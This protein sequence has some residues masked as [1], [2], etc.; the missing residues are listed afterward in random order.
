MESFRNSWKDTF[1]SLCRRLY[2]DIAVRRRKSGFDHK[3]DGRAFS[4]IADDLIVR[5]IMEKFSDYDGTAA[6]ELPKE[7]H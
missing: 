4:A 3:R 5:P 2:Q 1:F 6:F 7:Y